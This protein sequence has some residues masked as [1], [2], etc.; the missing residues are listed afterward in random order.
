MPSLDRELRAL[1][2]RSRCPADPHAASHGARDR[3]GAAAQDRVAARGRLTTRS[4]ARRSRRAISRS[5]SWATSTRL[6]WPSRRWPSCW[7]WPSR[8]GRMIPRSEPAIGGSATSSA[9]P[10]CAARCCFSSASGASGARRRGAGSRLWHAGHGLRSVPERGGH[11]GR[12]RRARCA[13]LEAGLAR[14]RL[15][16][17][18][19]AQERRTGPL[20]GAEELARMKPDA[21]LVNTA[22]GGL[23]DEA[24]LRV[25]ARPRPAARRGARRVRRRAAGPRPSACCART[26]CC[27][28]RIWPACRSNPRCG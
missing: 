18:A 2:G 20:I 3:G 8:C 25:R 22:R 16:V 27:S 4:M 10:S 28:A 19:R 26:A 15:R 6:P 13:S 7:P 14:G 9:P 17:A 1:H 11:P 12:W 23:I 21:C 5:P 24:A